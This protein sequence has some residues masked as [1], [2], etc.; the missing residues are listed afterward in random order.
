[1][2]GEVVS[3]FGGAAGG[4]LNGLLLYQVTGSRNGW[5]YSGLSICNKTLFAK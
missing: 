3:E 2:G 1:M 4:I 5:E